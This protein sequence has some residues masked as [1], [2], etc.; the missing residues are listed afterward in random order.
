MD[1]D[2]C[3]RQLGFILLEEQKNRSCGPVGYWSCT[4]NDT[5]QELAATHMKC[6]AVI[7][8]VILLRSSL[9]ETGLTIWT[10]H[11]PL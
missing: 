5:E 4:L 10:N 7:W 8:A 6:L 2:D 9:E 1:T 3:D 11:E